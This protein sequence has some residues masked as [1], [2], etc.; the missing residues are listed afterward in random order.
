MTGGIC[1]EMTQKTS[2]KKKKQM[3]EVC[4]VFPVQQHGQWLSSD[5][6]IETH[7]KNDFV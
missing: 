7:P 5:C 1:R 3:G 2:K 4:Q 6:S